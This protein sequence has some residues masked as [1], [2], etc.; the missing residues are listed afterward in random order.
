MD[1]YYPGPGACGGATCTCSGGTWQC[2]TGAGSCDASAP[3]GSGEAGESDGAVT[4]GDTCPADPPP[5]G[6]SCRGGLS[7]SYCNGAALCDCNVGQWE[8]GG[9]TSC[10]SGH[11]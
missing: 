5:V 3:D 11:D 9:S 4:D 7:C 6:G 8:C 1:C 2:F 10:M